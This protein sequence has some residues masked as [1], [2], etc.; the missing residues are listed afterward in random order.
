MAYNGG[1]I[2]VAIRGGSVNVGIDFRDWR[3]LSV[4]SPHNSLASEGSK[5][6]GYDDSEME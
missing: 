4:L 6:K 5:Q 3:K 2:A 1:K